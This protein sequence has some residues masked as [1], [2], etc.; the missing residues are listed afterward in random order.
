M[1]VYL[2]RSLSLSGD[3]GNQHFLLFSHGVATLPGI[4][5][6]VSVQRRQRSTLDRHNDRLTAQRYN[7]GGQEVMSSG[8]MSHNFFH[9][10]SRRT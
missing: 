10:V 3:V 5:K 1:A 9:L 4:K 2:S 7:R 6:V 8:R